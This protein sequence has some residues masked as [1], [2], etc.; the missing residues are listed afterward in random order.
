LWCITGTQQQADTKYLD[1]KL[2]LGHTN[3]RVGRNGAKQLRRSLHISTGYLIE[4]N[5]KKAESI[6][7]LGAKKQWC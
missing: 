2:V 4:L 6:G 3:G 7:N 1:N 5:M